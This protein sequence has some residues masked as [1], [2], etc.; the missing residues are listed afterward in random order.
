MC[1]LYG[2]HATE[3]TKVECT[4]VYAQNALIVQSWRDR[5]GGRHADGWGVA[6]YSDGEPVVERMPIAAYHGE[7]FRRSAARIFAHTVVAHV[8]AA[9]VGAVEPANTHP[10]VEGRWS[11]AHNGTVAHF[12]RL[13]E[14]LREGMSERHRAALRGTTDSEHLFRLLL[15]ELDRRPEA[16]PFAVLRDILARILAWSREIDPEA[17]PGLNVIWS[18]GRT[19]L[20][21]RHARPLFWVERDGIR[22]CEVCG[23][24]HVHHEPG[25]PYR[26][27][28]VASEPISEEAWREVP[29]GSALAVSADGDVRLARLEPAEPGGGSGQEGRAETRRPGG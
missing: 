3:P 17:R 10:F 16:G 4:L 27:V 13:R 22:D 9:T 23:F 26:A 11:F 18:D 29:E 12:D 5:A 14:R 1:R 15:S 25:M 7:H 6:V 8:R 28:V 19:L 20:A 2:F 24:P 21:S